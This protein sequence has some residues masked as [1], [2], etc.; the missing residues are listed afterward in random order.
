VE[1]KPNT[2]ILGSRP[3]VWM[4]YKAGTPKKKKGLRY[5]IKSKLG[6]PPV[7]LTDA[8]PD[9]TAKT[10]AGQLNNNGYFRSKV[11]YHVITK[12]K[13]SKIIYD[14]E[15]H[16]DYRIRAIDYSD[17]HDSIYANIINTV[18]KHS[19]LKPKQRYNLERLRA[20]QERIRKA[21]QDYGFYYFDDRYLIYEADSTV[22]DKQ[23]DLDLKLEPGIP[24]KA[25]RPYHLDN[26]TV[27]PDYALTKDTT[28]I[29]FDTTMVNHFTY[30]DDRH[31]FRPHVITD[32]INLK[33][34]NLYRHNDWDLTLNHLMGLGNF[35]FVNVKF[36]DSP[37][38]S[39]SLNASVY[40]TPLLKKS[41]RMEFQAVSKSNN[42]VGPGFNVT[43]TN[44]NFFRGAELFQLK[45]NT[46]YEWQTGRLHAGPL[47]SYEVGLESSVA[48]PRFITPI[49]IDY[50]SKRY[51]PQTIFK[52]GYTLQQRVSYFRLN[53][54]NASIGYT[55]R[56]STSKT[57]ALYPIDLNYVQL[58]RTSSV[59]DSLL[60]NNPVLTRAFEN[61][62]I[63]GLR[64]TF[65][66]NTQ[67]TEPRPDKF[68]ERH[69]RKS[70]FYFQGSLDIA[71]NL[72]HLYQR[73][74]TNPESKPYTLFGSP[75]SQYVRNDI[76]FRY[77]WQ[78][79]RR[80]KIATRILIGVGYPYGNSNTL[81]YIKQFAAGG[82][83]SIRAFPARSL[84]PGTY[85]VRADTNM[86][87]FFIDQRGDIKIEGNIEHR[88]DITKVVKSALFIDAGNI[89][90]WHNDP[91]RPGGAFDRKTFMQQLAVGAGFGLRFDFSFFVLRSDIGIPMR[92][93]WL[94]PSKRWVINDIDFG[95]KDWRAQN[96]LVNIAIGYPF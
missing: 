6:Q 43:F 82:A 2:M 24:D 31:D 70:N 71:G 18:K 62:F 40:L 15:L 61:Q 94:E 59:F 23:V 69:Y 26:V 52:V 29:P 58:S 12:R 8:K 54:L 48:V 78:M 20:E 34:G 22:G 33:P 95:S 11:K 67:L 27:L 25:K 38:D 86:K 66:L 17:M 65:T 14:V 76:D 39:S 36:A 96:I 5:L 93:P 77:Y 79:N 13:T 41:L 19:L 4:Y 7:L 60:R 3:S 64:Y 89:W 35:K 87:T 16:P 81:P 28:N 1:P 88:F 50:H 21:V 56:Q 75:Y 68:S 57:H 74:V 85:N 42:F 80:N 44:R 73:S 92:K 51:L 32:V 9:Q 49:R 45:L 72:L 47:N 84:G 91:N 53:S 10:L 30:V 55:W 37:K 63:P 83:N 46:G 90:L